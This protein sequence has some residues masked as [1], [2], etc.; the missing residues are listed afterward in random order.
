MVVVLNQNA[1]KADYNSMLRGAGWVPIGSLDVEKAKAAAHA[2]DEKS[3]RQHPSMFSF[4][5]IV[6]SMNMALATSNTK[7]LNDVRTY[8]IL[9]TTAYEQ[10]MYNLEN[11][12]VSGDFLTDLLL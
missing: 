3:Y 12:L 5:S 8:C 11:I 6:D 2:L 10:H 9:L 1:Y 7:Q 4:T